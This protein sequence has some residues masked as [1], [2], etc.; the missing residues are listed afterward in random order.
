MT[1]TF[2]LFNKEV[3][4]PAVLFLTLADP[5]AAI[6]GKYFGT[7]TLLGSK[8]WQGSLAFLFTGVLIV[9]VFT[10]FIWIGFGVALATTILEMLPL[11]V[12]D[13]ILIPT[14]AGILFHT[15]G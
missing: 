7:K 4:I 11:P 5:A 12:N 15:F 10:K 6:I 13:N 2:L 14:F 1:C 9:M 8:T 3:A